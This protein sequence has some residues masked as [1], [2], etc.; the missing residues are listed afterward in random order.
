MESS[1][2]CRDTLLEIAYDAVRTS[3]RREMKRSV[4]QRIKWWERERN[5]RNIDMEMSSSMNSVDSMNGVCKV[6]TDGIISMQC[7]E[8]FLEEVCDTKSPSKILLSENG[9]VWDKPMKTDIYCM[10]GATI[11]TQCLDIVSK[12]TKQHQEN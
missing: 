7:E 6:D 4:T 5:R 2:L 3:S 1:K 11:G 8:T 9:M 10:T 12:F